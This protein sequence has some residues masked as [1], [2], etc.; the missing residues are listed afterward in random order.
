MD[1]LKDIILDEIND[2]M[3]EEFKLIQELANLEFKQIRLEINNVFEYVKTIKNEN[4]N[5]LNKLNEE[6]KIELQ[7]KINNINKY[8]TKKICKIYILNLLFLIFYFYIIISKK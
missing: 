1:T 7:N 2:E 5:Y 3:Q 6:I 4:E 8:N